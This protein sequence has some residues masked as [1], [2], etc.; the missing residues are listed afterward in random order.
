MIASPDPE[1]P[2]PPPPP[3]PPATPTRSGLPTRK[4]EVCRGVSDPPPWWRILIVFSA[5]FA[6]ARRSTQM[7]PSVQLTRMSKSG[8]AVDD[9]FRLSD[10]CVDPD[11]RRSGPLG[12]GHALHALHALRPARAGGQ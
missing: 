10:A 5:T 11:P 1:P 7:A 12:S 4:A 6:G 2:P 3:P 8:V 9:S